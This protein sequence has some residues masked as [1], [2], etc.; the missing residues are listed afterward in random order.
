MVRAIGVWWVVVTPKG[1]VKRKPKG[2][3]SRT[4]QVEWSV[5]RHEG[6]CMAL[7]CGTRTGAWTGACYA[8][9]GEE[10]PERARRVQAH[11]RGWPR[12]QRGLSD[13]LEAYR[14]FPPFPVQGQ[15]AHNM[16]YLSAPFDAF[17]FWESVSV[18]LDRAAPDSLRAK[19]TYFC[20]SL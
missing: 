14:A 6:P 15:H 8:T 2:G 7:S 11:P 3:A 13:A 17:N 12:I 1:S 10:P 18:K 9:K 16:A 20:G 5:L 19:F 4:H